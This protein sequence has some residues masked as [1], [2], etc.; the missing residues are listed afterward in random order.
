MEF[1][2]WVSAIQ[3]GFA[4]TQ[5]GGITLDQ[6]YICF[7]VA[8]GI[9]LLCLVLGGVALQTMAKKANISGV[10]MGYL[11]FLNTYFAGK[12]A[13]E[14]NFFGQK[15]KRAGLYAMFAEII[16]AALNALHIVVIIVLSP[17]L[18]EMNQNGTI[19]YDYVDVP[20]NLSWAR[21]A[22]M[23]VYALSYIFQIMQVVFFFVLFMALFRKYYARS[24]I[25]MTVLCALFPFRA[26]V[27]FAVR[28]NMPVDYNA[29]MRRRAEEY[30]RARQQYGNMNG[31]YGGY[32][33]YNQPNGGYQGGG[34]NPPPA[35][36]PFSEFGGSGNSGSQSG[37]S[38]SSGNDDP[39]SE[40]GGGNGGN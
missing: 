9:L 7:G 18:S 38:G 25:L 37:N 31:G 1:F 28:N 34:Y 6:L 33:G 20:A 10:W 8:G 13:G 5:G 2:E 17:Y 16:Y 32:G 14:A 36:D 26:F 21:A 30:A 22:E 11:P 19:I 15:M 12:I 40:F 27:L 24:P 3:S 39:F 35:G 23:P 29:Y 4:I